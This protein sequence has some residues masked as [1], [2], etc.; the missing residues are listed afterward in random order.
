MLENE[1]IFLII[2]INYLK[3]VFT[4][5][6]HK[7]IPIKI[8]S[9]NFYLATNISI[10]FVYSRTHKKDFIV[11][12]T[13]LVFL[14]FP[15]SLNVYFLPTSSLKTFSF[16]SV[17]IFAHAPLYQIKDATTPVCVGALNARQLSII[18]IHR[19]EWHFFGTC[20]SERSEFCISF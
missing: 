13:K 17:D 8:L 12:Q 3:N 1:Y 14:I 7:K 19:R 20:K 18:N 9:N 2:N 10:N 11:I 15:E 5:I 6:F 4:K 16:A